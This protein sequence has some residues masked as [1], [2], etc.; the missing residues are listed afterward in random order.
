[1]TLK[2]YRIGDRV[3]WKEHATP[4][5]GGRPK[6]GNLAGEGYGECEQCGRDYFVI[7]NVNNDKICSLE[8]DPSKNGYRP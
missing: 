8:I 2:E 5:K 1:L 3:E 4:R 7:V 6:D